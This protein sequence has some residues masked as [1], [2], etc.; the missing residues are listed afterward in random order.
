M[1]EP[2][3][4]AIFY[5]SLARFKE[6]FRVG[7]PALLYHKI[8]WLKPRVRRRGLYISPTIFRQLMLE[9]RD[10]GFRCVLPG[11]APPTSDPGE[12][13]S[14]VITFDDGFAN[15][16]KYAAPVLMECGFR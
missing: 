13:N 5:D 14:I 12:T 3:V 7:Q 9:I 16:L 11:A 4:S 8:D 15:V 6:T 1:P 10:A 2:D